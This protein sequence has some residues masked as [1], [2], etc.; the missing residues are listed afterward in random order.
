[1]LLYLS[2]AGTSSTVSPT[3]NGNTV[4]LIGYPLSA[5]SIYFKPETGYIQY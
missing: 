5:T 2:T 1:V 3:G 4:R